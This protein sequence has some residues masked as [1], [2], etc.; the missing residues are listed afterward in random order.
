MGV[1]TLWEIFRARSSPSISVIL[2]ALP[3]SHNIAV[4]IPIERPLRLAP[5]EC[6]VRAWEGFQIRVQPIQ[7]ARSNKSLKAMTRDA[8]PAYPLIRHQFNVAPFDAPAEQLECCVWL[9]FD[10]GRVLGSRFPGEWL[11]RP[12]WFERE[13]G[14]P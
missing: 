1:A 13:P 12:S 11:Y 10:L 5:P 14:R 2:A 9:R 8:T 3:M 4:R 6:L 7:I